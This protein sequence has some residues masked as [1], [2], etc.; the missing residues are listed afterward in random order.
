MSPTI[1]VLA[2]TRVAT[3]TTGRVIEATLLTL[4]GDRTEAD[5]TTDHTTT[6]RKPEG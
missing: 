2:I 5:F 1:P 6:E 3:D 4:P